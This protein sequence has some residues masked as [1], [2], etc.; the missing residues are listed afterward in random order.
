MIMNVEKENKEQIEW[1]GRK[2]HVEFPVWWCGTD[3]EKLLIDLGSIVRHH[4]QGYRQ[5][6]APK[7]KLQG[8]V[9]PSF[10]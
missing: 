2:E 6:K 4:K 5:E 3:H 10:I 1:K 9:Y 8:K 7:Q